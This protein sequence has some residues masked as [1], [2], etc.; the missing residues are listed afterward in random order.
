MRNGRNYARTA[1]LEYNILNFSRHLLRRELERDGET[2]SFACVAERLLEFP[3]VH[4]DNDAIYPVFLMPSAALPMLPVLDGLVDG[5]RD[6]VVRIHL[7]PKLAHVFQF[8]RL[9]IRES[10]RCTCDVVNKNIKLARRRYRRIELADGTGSGISGICKRRLACLFER[11]IQGFKILGT[12]PHL[13]FDDDVDGTR[14]RERHRLDSANVIG[15][16]FSDFPVAA[17]RGRFEQTL[18][19]LKDDLQTVDLQFAY[20]CR[21]RVRERCMEEPLHA[22][23]EVVDVLRAERI[24]K[25][26]LRHLVPHFLKPWQGLPGNSL[27]WR[28]RR[29]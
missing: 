10:I 27:R 11:S 13:A 23:V 28:I 17:P 18:F 4:F 6:D 25:R 29:D 12:H 5:L 15:H 7:E 14:E 22:R 3:L 9:C 21:V 20:V 26:P 2:R 1:D 8:L 24:V 19:I 16:I